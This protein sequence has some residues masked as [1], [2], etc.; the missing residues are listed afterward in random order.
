[1]SIVLIDAGG[2]SGS[3]EDPAWR[4]IV[5][6]FCTLDAI[7]LIPLVY[8]WRC[9]RAGLWIGA[10]EVVIKGPF[11]TWKIPIAEATNFEPGYQHV[12]FP[13]FVGELLFPCPVLRNSRRSRIGVWALHEFT[14]R[15]F[16]HD[17]LKGFEPVCRQLNELL[18]AAR[19][20]ARG[21]PG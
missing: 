10:R 17:E 15:T 14:F 19:D 21:S 3:P 12:L 2:I 20:F 8:A 11:H 16:F 6:G 9:H 13:S 7:I 1:M 4:T 5:L 18:V